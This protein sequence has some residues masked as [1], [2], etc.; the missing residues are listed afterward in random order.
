[1]RETFPRN[2][3]VSVPSGTPTVITRVTIP[4]KCK[5]ITKE[6]GNYN[7]TVLAWGANQYW[8]LRFNG[9]P[10]AEPWNELHDQVGY[11]AQR[12]PMREFTLSGGVF[13]I[14]GFNTTGGAVNMGASLAYELES[15][16][17]V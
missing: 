11:G 9:V 4:P 10:L 14:W 12:Q 2:D 6:F 1:M 7:D 17:M 5:M 13:E 8:S 3:S 15:P 16:P